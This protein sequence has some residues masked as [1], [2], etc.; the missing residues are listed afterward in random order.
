M[1]TLV[2]EIGHALN[3][4]HSFDKG[5]PSALSW[6]NYPHLFPLGTEAGPGHNGT[7]EFWAAFEQTFDEL[8]LRH[9][10]HATPREIR[11]GGFEFGVY[12]EGASTIYPEAPRTRD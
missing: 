11:S 8:E 1:F 9:L 2:H 6:M 4:L 3:L 5:R 12:E 7:S 10:R